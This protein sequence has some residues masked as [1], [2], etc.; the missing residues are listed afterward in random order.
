MTRFYNKTSW[1]E[2][3][4]NQLLNP[5]MNDQQLGITEVV[6]QLVYLYHQDETDV[7]IKSMAEKLIGSLIDNPSVRL[8]TLSGNIEV[9]YK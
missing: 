3:R 4:K 8:D 9:F 5:D 1:E 7:Q 6:D 2:F